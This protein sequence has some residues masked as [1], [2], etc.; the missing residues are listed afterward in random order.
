MNVNKVSNSINSEN[1][2]LLFLSLEE[3]EVAEFINENLS[4]SVNSK[5]GFITISS[6]MMEPIIAAE[7][8]K[9]GQELLQKYIT[10]F[11]IEKVT[12]NLEFVSRNFEESKRSFEN[13]QLELARFRDSN[14]NFTTSTAKT[15]EERLEAEYALFLSI[16]TELAKQREQAKIAVT[17]NIP[18]LTIIEPVTIP[19]EKSKPNRLSMLFY[20]QLLEY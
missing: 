7:L 6:T 17:E 3:K 11:K 15:K 10:D 12:N 18:I 19:Y 14:I 4:I 8:V 13:K 9:K 2:N 5:E 1:T 20:F 16:Y